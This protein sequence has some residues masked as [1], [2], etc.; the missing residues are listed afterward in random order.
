MGAEYAR[1]EAGPADIRAMQAAAQRTWT[2]GQRRHIGDLAWG[3]RYLGRAALW[4]AADGEVAAWAIAGDS[5]YAPA[6][7][8]GEVI[9]WLG[10]PE[11]TVLETEEHLTAALEEAG[12]VRRDGGPFFL[13]CAVELDGLPELT[14]PE[15]YEIRAVRPDEAGQRAAAHRAA[16]RP[17]RIGALMVP[18]ADLGAGESS[19]TTEACQSVMDTW[20]YRADLDQVAVAPDGSFAAFALGWLDEVNKAG[21]L[22][23]VGTVPGHTR[24]GLA[25]AVSLASLHAMRAAGATRAVVYPRGDEAYPVARKV[26]FGLG[27]EPVARTVTYVRAT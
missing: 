21:E 10:E 8:A 4:T 24:R 23:P 16:W 20:P 2:P 11:I 9:G 3:L 6:G 26:Y 25:S 14:V 5:L 13:H 18:P 17:A 7:L 15:G 27:F 12:Y 22:E 1:R 19:M